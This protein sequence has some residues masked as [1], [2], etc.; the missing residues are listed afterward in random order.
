MKMADAGKDGNEY[1]AEPM[2]IVRMYDLT[3]DVRYFQVRPTKELFDYHPG[4]F[5]MLS[6]PGAG[7]APFSI[8]SS[9]SRSGMLEL[10]I[11]KAGM[12]TERLFD[13][14]ENDKVF[15]RGPY[16][17]GFPME[18]MR[19]HNLIFVA[20]GLGTVPLR[21]VL[22]YALDHREDFKDIYFLYGAR[23]PKDIL[24][25]WEMEGFVKRKDVKCY[26][27]VDSDPD[28]EWS[29][30]AGVVTN[31]FKHVK[32]IDPEDTYAVICGPPIM[33]RFVIK[34]LLKFPIPKHQ[35]LMTLERRMKCGIGKCGHC[36]VGYRY[37]CLDGP[38]FDYWDVM[39]TKGLVG[40]FK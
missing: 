29:H 33:Y 24:F 34:E 14:E 3:S 25:K 30:E 9:P 6:L 19:G 21:S 39:H 26:L 15:I 37:T 5:I 36:V 18:K 4:Q 35:I 23:T 13:L 17:N 8:S 16:G 10:G 12:L 38:V 1:D 32:D 7:D 28:N 31:L 22:L 11:R 40:G 20:G 27:S 2:K